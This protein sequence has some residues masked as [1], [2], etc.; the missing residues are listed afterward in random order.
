MKTNVSDLTELSAVKLAAV[1]RDGRH[2]AE[3]V[4]EAYLAHIA[5]IDGRIEAWAFLDPEY[6]RAQAKQADAARG[7]GWPIGPLHGVPVGI[8]DII[9]TKDMPTENGTPL[10]K[11]RRPTRDATVV[12]RLRAAGAVIL[13]KT[14][15]TELAYYSPNKTKNPHDATRTPGG[16]SSGSAAA[17]AASMAPVAIGTQ[18]NGSV[19]RPASFCGAVGYKATWGLIPRTGVLAQSF[20]LD[21]IGTFGRSVADA[22]LLADSLIGYDEGDSA[23]APIA[24]QGLLVAA[25]SEPS[26]RPRFAFVKTPVWHHAEEGTRE[27]FAEFAALLGDQCDTIDLPDIFNEG[28]AL[29]RCLMTA[30]FAYNFAPYQRRSQAQL[31]QQMRDAIDEGRAIAAHDY[32]AAVD[33]IWHLNAGLDQIFE[34]Y[35]AILTPAAAGAAPRGLESTGNPAFCTLWTLLG[36]PAITL[37]LL[38]DENGLPIGVQLVSRRGDDARLMRNAAWLVKTVKTTQA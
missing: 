2:S 22:A 34:H 16:S 25:Q 38:K 18:T 28:H 10:D 29:Q 8:K 30:G 15:T 6:A 31:S 11:G 17:V 14:V 19:I 5:S 36:T 27:A 20:H 4:V 21:T 7:K 32:L 37:P 9:D 33:R 3:E 13:G 35:D 12:A 24:H 23:T 26:S 1:I